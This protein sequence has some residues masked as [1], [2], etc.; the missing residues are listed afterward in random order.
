MRLQLLNSVLIEAMKRFEKKQW[1]RAD[2]RVYSERGIVYRS[3]VTI[4]TVITIKSGS[5]K[6]IAFLLHGFNVGLLTVS[7][8][9]FNATPINSFATHAV[10]ICGIAYLLSFWCYELV[11]CTAIL[12]VDG[13]E[14]PDTFGLQNIGTSIRC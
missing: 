14:R 9:L 4:M 10:P 5:P 11:L 6:Y 12:I 7:L 8:M 3:E 1:K 2:H 13:S